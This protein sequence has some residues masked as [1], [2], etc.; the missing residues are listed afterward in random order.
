MHEVSLMEQTLAIAIAQAEDHGASKIHRLTLRVGQQSGVVADALR[1][2]FEVVRQNTMAA[3]ARLEIE[4]IPVTC[5]C[6]HCH[7]NF[8]PEDWIY[9][10][11]HC[12]QISQTV[13]DGKQLELASLELS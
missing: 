4:E 9:R 8:Q 1:F 11:P 2:A 10:C 3:E 7:E 6:Q 13:M 12:D 5:R